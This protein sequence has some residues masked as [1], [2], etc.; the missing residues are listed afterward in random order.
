MTSRKK[1]VLNYT[2]IGATVTLIFILTSVWVLLGARKTTSDAIARISTFYLQ[3]LAEKRSGLVSAEIEGYFDDMNDAIE[4]ISEEDLK[5]VESLRS[6]LKRAR[7]LINVDRL[8]LVNSDGLVYTGNSTSSGMSRYGFLSEDITEPIIRTSNVYGA[9]PQVVLA[10][11]VSGLTFE[12][13]EFRV[14]FAQIDIDNLVAAIIAEEQDT[15]TYV[16]LFYRDGEP[17][18]SAS[19]AVFDAGENLLEALSSAQLSEDSSAEILSSDFENG[20]FGHITFTYKDTEGTV[21]YKP[22]EG[23]NWM[24]AVYVSSATIFSQ[25]GGIGKNMMFRSFLQILVMVAVLSALFI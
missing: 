6:Y 19:F 3:E 16:A 14:C 13:A 15:D 24:L 5:N 4:A 2:L 20:G 17:L 21:S 7:L 12:G 23:T 8:A 9:K 1:T 18:T 11:P 10:I 22:V 25:V